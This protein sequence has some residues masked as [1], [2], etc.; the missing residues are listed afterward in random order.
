M[1]TI[2]SCTENLHHIG[3]YGPTSCWRLLEV[4]VIYDGKVYG[5]CAYSMAELPV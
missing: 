4:V 3:L 5:M 1:L 2:D